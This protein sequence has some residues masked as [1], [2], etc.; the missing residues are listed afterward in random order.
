MAEQQRGS[1]RE[2]IWGLVQEKELTGE[3]RQ[4]GDS[5]KTTKAC[6]EVSL[7]WACVMP[8]MYLR[9]DLI[10]Q[11]KKLRLREFG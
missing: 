6:W 11:I 4:E 3:T 7:H 10:Q 2:G 8:F 1:E 5:R 9:S